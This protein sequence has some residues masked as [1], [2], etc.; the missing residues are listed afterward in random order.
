MF[1]VEFVLLSHNDQRR[2]KPVIEA[3]QEDEAMSIPP[4]PLSAQKG[5]YAILIVDD[6]PDM[7]LLCATMLASDGFNVLQAAG[8]TEA[9]E[10]CL[11]HIGEI[12]LALVDV[13]LPP[14]V[15][16]LMTERTS[17]PRV[18]GHKLMRNLL[19]KRKGLRAVMMSAHSKGRLMNNGINLVK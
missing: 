3:T 16:R 18:H 12:H 1:G 11:R 19:A 15:P 17:R 7:R 6:D 2:L 14:Q 9:M 10:I 8:S 5:P 13:M 4:A